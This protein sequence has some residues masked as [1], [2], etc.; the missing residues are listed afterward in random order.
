M[1]WWELIFKN[2]LRKHGDSTL[3][4]AFG[5]LN[6]P[7]IYVFAVTCLLWIFCSS[8]FIAFLVLLELLFFVSDIEM[9]TRHSLKNLCLHVACICLYIHI[10]RVSLFRRSHIERER[11]NRYSFT[12]RGFVLIWKRNFL[13]WEQSWWTTMGVNNLPRGVVESPSLEVFQDMI[14]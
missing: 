1:M 14:R 13:P 5:N 2:F 9:P 10:Y 3:H 4:S 11:G 12:G 8:D 7:D 6:L